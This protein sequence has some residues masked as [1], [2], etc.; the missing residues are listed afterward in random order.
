M[1]AMSLRL[2]VVGLLAGVLAAEGLAATATPIEK[3]T[4]LLKGLQAKITAEGIRRLL[5]KP[6]W[7]V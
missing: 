6:G 1:R 2:L 3:V 4:E 7:F 5:L